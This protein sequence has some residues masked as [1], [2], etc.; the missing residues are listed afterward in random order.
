[1]SREIG[2]EFWDVPA[3]DNTGEGNRLFPEGTA[4]YL[5]GR[6]AL[7]A[8]LADIR[9]RGL[10]CGSA[11][12]PAWC[13]GSMAEPFLRAGIRVEFYPV[14]F[15]GRLR[16]EPR[17][18]CDLLLVMDYFGAAGP[19]PELRGYRGTVIRDETHSL[20]SARRDDAAY[21]FGSLRKWCGVW[22]GGF[23]RAKNGGAL[24]AD[25]MKNEG[26]ER[27]VS[28]R[29]EAMERK[30]AYLAGR[31][32]K[33][34]LAL[35]GEAEALLDTAEG[36]AQADPRDREL[37]G[38]LDARRIREKRRENAEVLRA[39]LREWLMFPDMG[40][41]DCPLFVPVLV[42]GE[43]RDAL[44]QALTSQEIYCPVHW[45]AADGLRPDARVRAILGSE[46]SLVCDQRY[47]PEDMERILDVIQTFR[48]EASLC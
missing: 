25:S 43:K 29:R 9:R 45:P 34:Y 37:A 2:S 40:E 35:F 28:L 22:T 33:D 19:A 12:L 39:G 15:D 4:W 27:Y 1:M 7:G 41:A 18:D 14:W 6:T 30:R 32:G 26:A 11:A 8:V 21:T 3:G 44:R 20:F 36:M 47:T 46:L 24:P 31:G 13:C 16:Q 17:T 42:P 5:S 23:A 10:A 38:R 48:K